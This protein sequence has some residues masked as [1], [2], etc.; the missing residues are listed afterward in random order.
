MFGFS[1]FTPFKFAPCWNGIAWALCSLLRAFQMAPGP[2]LLTGSWAQSSPWVLD[3]QM[4]SANVEKR[5]DG[6]SLFLFPCPD[7]SRPQKRTYVSALANGLQLDQHRGR[8]RRLEQS[9]AL[10]VRSLPTLLAVDRCCKYTWWILSC[11]HVLES[12]DS[13]RKQ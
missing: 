3:T 7:T 9:T 8:L 4:V 13:T 12:L 10:E 11:E 5:N 6:I 2:C 1:F